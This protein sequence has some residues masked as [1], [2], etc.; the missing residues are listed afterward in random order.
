MKMLQ[1]NLFSPLHI[2]TGTLL[3][4]EHCYSSH[5]FTRPGT[6][7]FCPEGRLRHST[8]PFRFRPSIILNNGPNSWNRLPEEL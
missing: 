1:W 4:L 3:Y 7:S 8:S 6:H 2:W 5:R